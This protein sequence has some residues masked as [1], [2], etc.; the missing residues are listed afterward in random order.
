[1]AEADPLQPEPEP[2]AP[3]A[4]QVELPASPA[5]AADDLGTADEEEDMPRNVPVSAIKTYLFDDPDLSVYAIVDGA[6]CADLLD[7][8]YDLRPEFVCLY[9]GELEPDMAEVA[10]YLV[11]LIPDTPFTDWLLRDGWG[12][13]WGIFAVTEADLKSMRRHLRT[14]LMVHDPDGK[15]MYFRYYDP[16]VF[17]AYL[18]TCNADET[19][20]VFGPVQSYVLE[21]KEPRVMLRF[22]P[23]GA[24]AQMESLILSGGQ[25]TEK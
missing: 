10:P 16:R 9:S 14:F 12:R 24:T 3:T 8:L 2:Q 19:T 7:K 22:R 20:T 21:H 25:G 6:N 15:P 4:E 23:K 18:P 1:M 13:S 11:R 17:R 5:P